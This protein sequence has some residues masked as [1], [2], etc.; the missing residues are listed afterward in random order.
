MQVALQSD[1]TSHVG[2]SQL[3]KLAL[4]MQHLGMQTIIIHYRDVKDIS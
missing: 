1:R 2:A 3:P 4:P